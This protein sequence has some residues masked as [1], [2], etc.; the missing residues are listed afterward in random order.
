MIAEALRCRTYLFWMTAL[1]L[2]ISFSARAEDAIVDYSGYI[3]DN[4]VCEIQMQV[5]A[6]DSLPRLSSRGLMNCMETSISRSR[7]SGLRTK[8]KDADW[9]EASQLPA[10][11]IR[12]HVDVESYH[13]T[14][15]NNPALTRVETFAITDFEKSFARLRVGDSY[16]PSTSLIDQFRLVGVSLNRNYLYSENFINRP[17]GEREIY[18]ERPAKVDVYV[19]FVLVASL[20]LQAGR[21]LL[22]DIPTNQGI[23]SVVLRITEAG[24]SVRSVVFQTAVEDSL[25][26]KGYSDYSFNLGRLNEGLTETPTYSNDIVGSAVYRYGVTNQLTLGSSLAFRN[27]LGILGWDG[28]LATTQG[29]F[30]LE[31]AASKNEQTNGTGARLSYSWICNCAVVGRDQRFNFGVETYSPG[32]TRQ[33]SNLVTSAV[34]FVRHGFFSSYSQSLNRL[35]SIRLSTTIN[36]PYTSDRLLYTGAVEYNRN[37]SNQFLVSARYSN[38]ILERVGPSVHEVGL[39]LIY[40][41]ASG[42][43]TA[44]ANTSIMS[45]GPSRSRVGT[46]YSNPLKYESALGEVSTDGSDSQVDLQASKGFENIDIGVQSLTSQMDR[47]FSQRFS[48]NPSGS[49]VFGGGHFGFGRYIR[50]SYIVFLNKT[51]RPIFLNG[52]ADLHEAVVK[53][54]GTSVIT[55]TQSYRTKTIAVTSSGE[56]IYDV[57][58]SLL[59]LKPRYKSALIYQQK[60]AYNVWLTGQ[61][62][63]KAGQPVGMTA[64]S[65]S[66]GTQEPVAFFTD[67]DG[68]FL[69]QTAGLACKL[70][71]D[72]RPFEIGY[73]AA[74][75]IKDGVKK[76][77]PVQLQTKKNID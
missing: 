47:N 23:N 29:I 11:G 54:G 12:A 32:F 19:N 67:T 70:T 17:L 59:R 65:M 8:L 63:D 16:S 53:P 28:T 43:S 52:D 71:V 55:N 58:E 25:F 30:K 14:T 2:L 5:P 46:N 50:D 62:I 56:N 35:S 34:P 24:G 31:L 10:L 37:I 18:L 33:V 22:N 38:S 74:S 60:Q 41:F 51:D 49:V 64:G 42:L 6:D 27:S 66:C 68:T 20:S 39:Q 7:V 45:E 40:R 73:I 21:H 72:S 77:G 57:Q 69:V 44:T 75:N 15:V 13:R 4:Y 48:L 26:R 1:S 76:L 36:K 3:G 9:V 61:L